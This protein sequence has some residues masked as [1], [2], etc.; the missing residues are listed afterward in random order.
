MF[1]GVFLGPILALVLFNTVVLVLVIRVL[2]KHSVRKLKDKEDKEKVQGTF[3]TL[4]SVASIML[5]FGLQWLFGALTIAEASIAFQWLF[6]IFSTL[7]GFLI[8]VFFCVIG[9]DAREEWLNVFS[10]GRRF[11]RKDGVTTS[12]AST[13]RRTSTLSTKLSSNRN[14]LL[15]SS[16]ADASFSVQPDSSVDCTSMVPV[17]SGNEAQVHG[18]SE[19]T[20]FV[21]TNGATDIMDSDMSI[22]IEETK[23][24]SVDYQVPP[25]ILERKLMTQPFGPVLTTIVISP[26][27]PMPDKENEQ[28]SHTSLYNDLS[29]DV[30]DDNAE[31]AHP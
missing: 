25:H 4:I 19:E 28:V 10:C 23:D 27:T 7:Q 22:H 31:L 24:N 16:Q 13:N 12:H 11:K 9:K 5:M 6:V 20:E 2:I 15:R 29:P 14:Y 17:L 18:T 1:F 3:K 21:I 30:S 8:F 26:P